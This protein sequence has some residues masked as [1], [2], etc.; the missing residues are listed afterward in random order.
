VY[1]TDREAEIRT[2]FD[3]RRKCVHRSTYNMG[4]LSS[5]L[6]RNGMITIAAAISPYN[7]VRNKARAWHNE[8]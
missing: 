3:V 6:S 7:S 4:H 2:V 8:A 1:F 5:L